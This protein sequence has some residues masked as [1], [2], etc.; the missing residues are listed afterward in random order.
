M[1]NGRAEA[2]TSWRLP[3]RS[4][5]RVGGQDSEPGTVEVLTGLARLAVGRQPEAAV[6]LFAAAEAIQTRAG[7][8]LA[9]G[10]RAT[11]CPR[12]LYG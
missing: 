12:M 3:A 5:R 6:R 7:L 11:L 2:H 8:I 4:R 10:L 1:L 9:P